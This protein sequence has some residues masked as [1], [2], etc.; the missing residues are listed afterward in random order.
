[1]SILTASSLYPSGADGYLS[2]LSQGFDNGVVT[3]QSNMNAALSALQD[4][5]SD[6]AALANYQSELSEY[7]LYRNAQSA[8]VK[9]MKDTATSIITN[10]R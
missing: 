7:N 1:M 10:Y 9:T 5:P 8:A 2:D 3:M 6:P 4:D